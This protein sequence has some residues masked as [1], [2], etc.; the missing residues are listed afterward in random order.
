MSA[1]GVPILAADCILA[2]LS[3]FIAHCLKHAS[4][5]WFNVSTP[6]TSPCSLHELH[7]LPNH[8]SYNLH[9]CS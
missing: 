3:E 4:L 7:V 6:Q 2:V 1:T 9:R 5:Y 8:G